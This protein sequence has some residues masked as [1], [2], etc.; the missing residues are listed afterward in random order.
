M[1]YSY[2]CFGLLHTAQ[3]WGVVLFI[4][5]LYFDNLWYT[6]TPSCHAKTE[7]YL[8][9]TLMLNMIQYLDV[10]FIGAIILILSPFILM[11][12]VFYLIRYCLN[13]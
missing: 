8:F 1:V 7:L 2:V 9:I 11:F 3:L 5:F 13:A 12:G 10:Y 6:D 4:K